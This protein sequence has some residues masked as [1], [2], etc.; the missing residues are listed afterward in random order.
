MAAA[1]LDGLIILC[2]ASHHSS[3]PTDA[4]S[5]P[6]RGHFEPFGVFFET[7]VVAIGVSA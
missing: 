7:Q 6:A 4:A 2:K 1:R 5:T 3:L